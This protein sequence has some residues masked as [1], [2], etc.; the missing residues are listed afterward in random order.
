M[1]YQINAE[2]AAIDRIYR[3]GCT[4]KGNRSLGRD[5]PRQVFRRFEQEAAAFAIRRCLKQSCKA[6]DMAHSKV[7][8][9]EDFPV[10]FDAAMN[11]EGPTFVEVDMTSIGPF[12]ETFAGPPAG[13]AGGKT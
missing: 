13:A 6:I 9:I 3:Q 4:V 2:A 12:A 8:R 5:K 1:R 10:T 7:T 11:G